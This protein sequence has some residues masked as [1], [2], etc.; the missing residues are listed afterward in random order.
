[1][2]GVKIHLLINIMSNLHEP[3]KILSKGWERI[4]FPS[5]CR[6][7]PELWG[8][9]PRV[10][11][12]AKIPSDTLLHELIRI[13]QPTEST[14]FQLGKYQE[15][16]LPQTYDYENQKLLRD[17]SNNLISQL[18][19]SRSSGGQPSNINVFV[20]DFC[21]RVNICFEFIEHCFLIDN[22]CR[23]ILT[24]IPHNRKNIAHV[25]L[26]RIFTELTRNIW[27]SKSE[28]ITSEIKNL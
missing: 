23:S 5:L 15:K 12:I 11:I 13:P 6:E 17:Y 10:P 25:K 22:Y 27:I 28:N 2:P 24:V 26:N 16:F 14:P 19:L 8:D 1:M 20:S 9:T 21:E 7:I 3:V 4:E 18:S